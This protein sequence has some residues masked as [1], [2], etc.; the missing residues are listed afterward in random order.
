[1]ASSYFVFI[2][3]VACFHTSHAAP[4]QGQVTMLWPVHFTSTALSSADQT[5]LE[6]A[7]FGKELAEIGL[8]GFQR[9]RTSILPRE[10]ELDSKFKN[11]FMALDHSR[12]NLAFR[13]WQT[14]AFADTVNMS[15]RSITPNGGRIRRHKEISYTWPELYDN[16]T[17]HRLEVRI[18]EL[19]RLYLARTG[20]KNLTKLRTFIWAEVYAKGDALRPS[21]NM[22]GAYL[23]GRYFAKTVSY[24]LKLNFEDPRGVNPPGGKTNSHAV[25]EGNIVLQPTW[26]STFMTPN[27]LDDET[28]CFGFLV[29]PHDGPM[30]DWRNDL[31]SSMTSKKTVNLG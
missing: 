2:G 8:K 6:T 29:Y 19:S 5:S 28:V 20:Y 13:Q 24:S 4:V 18:R 16:P 15:T 10:L 22:D 30:A 3:V 26:I 7:E 14:N 27:M 1:M 21:S 23:M 12:V 17:F 31:T 9:Y 25:Y 11:E